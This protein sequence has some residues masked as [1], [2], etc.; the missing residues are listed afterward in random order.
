MVTFFRRGNNGE[1]TYE[2]MFGTI[3][4]VV[5]L[6]ILLIVFVNAYTIAQNPS[7]KVNTWLPE[8]VKE[9]VAS[10]NWGS[11]GKTV[12]FND[13]TKQGDGELVAWHWNFGD[14]SVSTE[15][16]PQHNYSTYGDFTVFLEVEDANGKHSDV[17]TIVSVTEGSESGQTEGEFSLELGDMV[18]G[19]STVIVVIGIYAVLVMISGRIMFAG[20]HLLRP[21][22]K[23]VKFKVRP[24]TIDVDVQNNKDSAH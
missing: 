9:P 15:R 16:N 2:K 13:D 4:V 22:T 24:K 6:V 14:G 23:T 3:L 8:E 18:N 11:H 20:V 12:V 5:G 19:I 10:F 7:E 1:G 17:D 21:V